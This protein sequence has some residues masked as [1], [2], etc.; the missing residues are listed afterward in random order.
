MQSRGGARG[1]AA[2]GQPVTSG[3]GRGR[4]ALLSRGP[5]G[6]SYLTAEQERERDGLLRAGPTAYGWGDQRWT[7]ARVGVLIEERFQVAYEISGGWR[8]LDRLGWSWQVPNVRVVERD[9]EAIA[10]W[11]TE[12]WPAASHPHRQALRGASADQ[13][14]EIPGAW[15]AVGETCSAGSRGVNDRRDQH[16][17][18]SGPDDLPWLGQ[19][20]AGGRSGPAPSFAA[21]AGGS[22]SAV[23]E[24]E[25]AGRLRDW[26]GHRSKPDQRRCSVFTYPAACDVELEVLN[27]VTMVLVAREGHRACKPRS[28]RPGPMRAGQPA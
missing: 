13:Q 14:P 24:G 26:A 22:R 17:T 21:L 5:G 27:M 15:H 12:T 6:N 4:E 2:G 9:E 20:P 1:D 16:V 18:A 8:L 7:L 19:S 28:V 11:R 23:D 25:R 10:A 3:L